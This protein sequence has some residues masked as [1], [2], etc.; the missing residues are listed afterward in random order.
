MDKLKIPRLQFMIP[1]NRHMDLI[2]NN[3]ETVCISLSKLLPRDK[4]LDFIEGI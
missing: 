1:S 2:Y 4:T 3:I